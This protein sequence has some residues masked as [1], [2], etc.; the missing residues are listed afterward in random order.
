MG[1]RVLKSKAPSTRRVGKVLYGIVVALSAVVVL[2][3]CLFLYLN[4]PPEHQPPTGSKGVSAGVSV[5]TPNPLNPDSS[6]APE[7]E[8]RAWRTYTYT[9]LLVATDQVSGSTD[10]PYL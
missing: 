2:L 9:F 10:G 6:A 4:R 5:P 8:G 3:Y 1:R 7:P